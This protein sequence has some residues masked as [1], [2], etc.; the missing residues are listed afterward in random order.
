MRVLLPEPAEVDDLWSVYALPAQPHVRAG[1]VASVDGAVVVDGSSRPLSSG[2]DRLALRT[3][4][5]TADVVLV[6]AGTARDEDYGPVPVREQLRAHRRA[7]GMAERP[8]L[9]VVTRTLD[10][11]PGARLLSDPS[12]PVLLLAPRS[13]EPP[14]PLPAHAEVVRCG[15]DDVDLA[16]ALDELRA[17]GLLRVLCEGGPSLLQR[18]VE[19]D[20]VD[21]L[22]LTVAPT[23]VGAAPGL[24]PAAL[25]AP[26]PVHLAGLV[27]HDG[28]LLAR[29]SLRGP[30]LPT[31]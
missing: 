16:A 20:L 28:V 13:A 5:A 21:E 18:M 22:C 14:R 24:L 15:D 27:E 3:L 29:W 9:A 30:A 4:R 2:P 26:R 23:L 19:A 1:F 7:A 17:R 6:G 31:T 10:L 8:R 25:A 12:E 11:D